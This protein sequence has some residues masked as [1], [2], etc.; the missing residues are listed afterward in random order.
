LRKNAP[1]QT[2]QSSK[3]IQLEQL[4]ALGSLGP[5]D[6]AAISLGFYHLRALKVFPSLLDLKKARQQMPSRML[7]NS[8][9]EGK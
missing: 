9:D 5:P 6:P 8:P 3:Q 1:A 4:I 2:A 7:K